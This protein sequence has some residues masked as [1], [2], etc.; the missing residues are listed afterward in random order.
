MAAQRDLSAKRNG[1]TGEQVKMALHTGVAG[2]ATETTSVLRWTGLRL[3]SAARDGQV[4]VS[5]DTS[6]LVRDTSGFSELGGGAQGPRRARA[7]GFGEFR[8]DFPTRRYRFA[9]VG[10]TADT[11][12]V[13]LRRALRAQGTHR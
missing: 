5:A 1:H 2:N 3:L 13:V 4:L 9:R 12:R 8:A 7:G 11:S 10:A 6:E